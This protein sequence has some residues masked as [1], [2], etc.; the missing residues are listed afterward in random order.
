MKPGFSA[1]HQLDIKAAQ[2]SFYYLP[3][4]RLP[5]RV[6]DYNDVDG[7]QGLRKALNRVDDHGVMAERKKLLWDVR[8]HA[9]AL[10]TGHNDRKKW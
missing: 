5:I 4:V 10:A 2:M 3:K 7:W 9:V 1:W 8:L 6:D